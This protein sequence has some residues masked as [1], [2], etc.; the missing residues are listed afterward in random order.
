MVLMVTITAV[1]SHEAS[2]PLT[3]INNLSEKNGLL[4]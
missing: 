1:S 3:V 2:D 4:Q